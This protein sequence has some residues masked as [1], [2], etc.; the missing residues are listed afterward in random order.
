MDT[1]VVD[2]TSLGAS[3]T[4][5]RNSLERHLQMRPDAK[6]L[7]DR[8]ILLDTSVA[9]S[10][11]AARQDLARQ[12]TTDALKKQLEHRPERGELVERNILPDTTAA[13]ALQAHARDLERQMRADRLDHKIQERPQPEQLIEQ[14]ILSEEEDPRRG[15][16]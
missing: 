6:D 11:Q 7:K 4:E 13:P 1:P 3:P 16:A 10:L 12:R 15:A 5:R 8:H 14:G 2:H 9:P